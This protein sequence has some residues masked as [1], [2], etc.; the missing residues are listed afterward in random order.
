MSGFLVFSQAGTEAQALLISYH[1]PMNVMLDLQYFPC[2]QYMSK[3]LLYERVIIDDTGLFEKQ[4]YRNRCYIAGANGVLPL[5]IPVHS[6]RARLPIQDIQIDNSEHWQHRH[7]QS[8]RSAYG[9]TPFFEHYAENLEIFFKTPHD[10]LFPLVLDI[11]YTTL[12]LLHIP[13]GRVLLRSQA[14][15]KGALDFSNK[16]HPKTKYRAEDNHFTPVKYYQAFSERHG[17]LSNL[18]I[19]D[20]LFNEG[21]NSINILGKCIQ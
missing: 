15:L 6:S 8:I 11:L 4:S 21:P 16:I 10:T 14:G 12:K 1:C 17:F 18:S 13:V 19:L 3:F 7:W 20:L 9:K 2:I 5:V